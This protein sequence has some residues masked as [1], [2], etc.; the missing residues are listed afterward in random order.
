MEISK[1]LVSDNE[2][3]KIV[4]EEFLLSYGIFEWLINSG[5]SGMVINGRNVRYSSNEFKEYLK[6]EIRYKLFYDPRY[7]SI[8][9]SD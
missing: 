3:E 1:E 4:E 7:E 9:D 5:I 8:R 2:I 6:G